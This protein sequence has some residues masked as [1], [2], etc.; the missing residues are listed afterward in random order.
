MFGLRIAETAPDD[1][2]I[3]L[4]VAP[5]FVLAEDEQGY[6]EF[7][8]RMVQEFA[9]TDDVAT[10]ERTC[11][12]C[13]LRPGAIEMDQLPHELLANSLDDGTA[14]A[15]IAPWLWGARALVD[16]RRGDAESAIAS[17]QKSEELKPGDPA[18]ALNLAIRAMAF[19]QIGQ[20]EEARSDMTK[21]AELIGDLESRMG[22]HHDLLMAT[23]LLHEA[24]TRILG[25]V[26]RTST[27]GSTVSSSSMTEK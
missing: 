17:V 2:M 11:K 18:R 24:P 20:A 23:I 5:S 12:A 16:L 6:H 25:D 7:C 8:R 10:A 21:A 9:Q 15:I 27:D 19:E 4:R 22:R 1:T 26:E 13:L 14:P 3:W